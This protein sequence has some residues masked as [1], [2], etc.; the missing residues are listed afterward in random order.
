MTTACDC[1]EDYG[2]CEAHA[3]VLAQREGAS[4]RTADELCAVFI[5]DVDALLAE[6]G[7]TP[8]AGMVAA[9]GDAEAYW[10]A[11]PSGGWAPIGGADDYPLADALRDALTFAEQSLPEGV[12]VWWDD[13]YVIS[14]VTGG[15]LHP[16]WAE[17]VWC[18]RV[19]RCS[20]AGT[21]D[22]TCEDCWHRMDWHRSCEIG[23]EDT[24][25][26]FCSAVLASHAHAEYLTDED[27][28]R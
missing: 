24:V 18:G 7:V 6:A 10:N 2:P 15:P 8:D 9:V 3:E 5:G 25:C 27:G 14:R 28:D 21:G 16:D 13:G 23:D 22:A 20:D 11:C 12:Y 19:A 26:P 1:S 4:L 17:C